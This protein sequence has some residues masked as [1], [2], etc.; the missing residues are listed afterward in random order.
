MIFQWD[1]EAW[2]EWLLPP[3]LRGRARLGALL[4]VMLEG[5]RW[6]YEAFVE[7]RARTLYRLRYTGQTIWLEH[8]L[9]DRFNGGGPAFV[10]FEQRTGPVGIWIGEPE[11]YVVQ[12]YR[13]NGAE[14]R[15]EVARWTAAELAAQPA[16]TAYSYTAGE[17]GAN[18]D[19]VVWVP[20]GVLDV[21][22]AGNA[23]AVAEMR[24]WIEQYRI[25][26]SRYEIKN[27]VP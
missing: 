8:L 10:N 12:K 11:S 6:A 2:K 4:S 16:L 25:A 3:K 15:Y 7:H 5:V 21:T 18:L 20:A 14:E 1:I 24:G 13:W 9:N 17:L 27:Y 26:G 23:A 22:D 19:F